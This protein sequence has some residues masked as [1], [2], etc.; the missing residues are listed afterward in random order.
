M[1]KAR[2][3]GLFAVLLGVTLVLTACADGGGGDDGGATTTAS[4]GGGEES[5][6]TASGG[7][8]EESTT[9]AAME[10]AP[11]KPNITVMPA[12]I[13]QYLPVFV[14]QEQGFFANYGLEPEI[15]EFE[16]GAGRSTEAA[17]SGEA[18]L[19]YTSWPLAF[20]LAERGQQLKFITFHANQARADGVDY[21]THRLIVT[22]D[23]P[24]QTV[25]DLEG[26]RIAMV[27]RGSNEEA[28]MVSILE[29]VGVDPESV[30]FI[31]AFWADHPALL[32]AGEID[33]GY[34]IYPFVGA[35]IPSGE[36]SGNGFRS[37]GDPFLG[38][39]NGVPEMMGDRGAALFPMATTP[40]FVEANPNTIRA[41]ALAVRDAHQWIVD[42][43]A[44]ALELSVEP[45]GV[46][47]EAQ[48]ANP[49][50]LFLT[51]PEDIED[52]L[53]L[54]ADFMVNADL[55]QEGLDLS[56]FVSDLPFTEE[57]MI[58]PG[59]TFPWDPAALP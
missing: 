43:P 39:S 31:E 30:E 4:G 36:T 25:A 11:E 13:P 17:L 16:G 55:L 15:L 3:K 7:G 26:A 23:S 5:T 8:G 9:T 18:D 1:A 58:E 14:A 21:G 22:E 41:W 10:A 56:S 38:G 12:A 42:N 54:V 44:E 33:V 28:F 57:E 45:T 52:Q 37:I 27:A 40:E 2:L 49:P 19:G 51:W 53:Q 34:M 29:Q 59:R 46:P 6:T 48:K 35:I 50:H 47:A 32:E 20:S 24:I